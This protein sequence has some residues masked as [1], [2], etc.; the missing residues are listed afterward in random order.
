VTEVVQLPRESAGLWQAAGRRVLQA[1]FRAVWG[2][3]LPALLAG[4]V[5]RYL[6]PPMGSGVPGAVAHL[7]R[8]FPLLLGLGLFLLF[9]ALAYYWQKRLSEHLPFSAMFVA[10]ARAP[11]ARL[12]RRWEGL[13]L[14]LMVVAALGAAVVVRSFVR[15]FHVL[16]ESMLPTLEPGD[17][18]AGFVRPRA[19]NGSRAP[20]RG[21]VVAFRGTMTGQS[22]SA[23]LP[24]TLLKRVVG[25]PGDRIE[26]QGDSPVINGWRVP[27]CE[28]GE[29]LYVVPDTTGRFL[30]GRLFVEFLGDRA[31]L[32]V[33]SLGR[34]F[35]GA[36]VVRKGEAFVLGDNRGNSTDSRSYQ[37]GQGGGVPFDA[38]EALAQ[39]FL[40]GTRLNGDADFGRLLR[41]LDGLE[42]HVRLEGVQQPLE[43]QRGIARCLANRPDDTQPP[44]PQ[45]AE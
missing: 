29:Y 19:S 28:A 15:P 30:H 6:V 23:G 1:L 7:G 13:V 36:Y 9:S 38:M 2:V 3:V 10:S 45:N 20:R 32:T 35:Q 44:P 18:V 16:G 11:Q 17:L 27:S 12:R 40:I 37:R 8:G 39:R 41:P 31:Y 22:P 43:L 42:V 34:P 5:L 4:V 25:L 33:H 21:D 14:P 26:M 24:D